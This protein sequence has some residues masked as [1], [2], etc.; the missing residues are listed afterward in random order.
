MQR[1]IKINGHEWTSHSTWTDEDGYKEIRSILQDP[2]LKDSV[3]LSIFESERGTEVQ[4]DMPEG[5]FSESWL[6][7]RLPIFFEY[8]IDDDYDAVLNELS[9]YKLRFITCELE[10]VYNEE[11][12][13]EDMQPEC[14]PLIEEVDIRTAMF[15]AGNFQGW[16]PSCSNGVQSNSDWVSSRDEDYRTGGETEYSIHFSLISN[17]LARVIGAFLTGSPN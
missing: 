11:G 13:L 8:V 7:I 5:M 2:K 4:I 17:Q 1:N 16:E 14:E 15:R 6:P 9:A 12:E 3:K 10:P